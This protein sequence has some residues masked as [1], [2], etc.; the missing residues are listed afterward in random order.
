MPQRAVP[1]EILSEIRNPVYMSHN[2]LGAELQTLVQNL[3]PDTRAIEKAISIRILEEMRQH[4]TEEVSQH[5]WHFLSCSCG[6]S[7][8]LLFSRAS[9]LSLPRL[10]VNIS[11]LESVLMENQNKRIQHAVMIM[12]NL[13]AKGVVDDASSGLRRWL[14]RLWGIFTK[15]RYIIDVVTALS[16]ITSVLVCSLTPCR[17]LGSK[18]LT[19]KHNCGQRF[20]KMHIF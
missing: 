15:E 14:V 17:G 18:P 8:T 9:N 3:K 20:F 16:A 19:L 5:A 1:E 6:L 4:H 11:L 10:A 12:R 13:R 7:W 2:N